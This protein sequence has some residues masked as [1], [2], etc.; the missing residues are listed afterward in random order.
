MK[1]D[2][3]L[4]V[5]AEEIKDILRKFDI[6][7]AITLH[8]PGHGEYFLHLNPSYSCAYMHEDDQI[9]FFS[10]I[11]NYVDKE[12]AIKHQTDTANMLHILTQVTAINFTVLEQL[13][14]SLDDEIGAIH[15]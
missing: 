2:V 7:G 13:S 1:N 5:A 12:T 11:K 4:K 6:A 3:K 15:G 8:A 14:K 9:R 10:K